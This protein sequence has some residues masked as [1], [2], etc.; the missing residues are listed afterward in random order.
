[1]KPGP[2]KKLYR[3]TYVETRTFEFFVEAATRQRGEDI[4]NDVGASLEAAARFYVGN[5]QTEACLQDFE[6]VPDEVASGTRPKTMVVFPSA[7]CLKKM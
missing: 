2:K 6:Q 7:V 3:A 5:C 4:A 1:M